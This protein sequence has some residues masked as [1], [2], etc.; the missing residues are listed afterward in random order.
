M[1]VLQLISSSGYYGTEAV[2]VSLSHALQQ[3]GVSSIV[4]VFR[5][6]SKPN[7]ELAEIAEAKALPVELIACNGRADRQ[8]W[9]AIREIIRREGIDVLHSHGYKAH[10]YGHFAARGT[11]CRTVATCHGHHTKNSN[12][13]VLSVSRVKVW[14]FKK[15]ERA[16]LPRFDR[17]IAV[18][19]QIASS[20]RTAGVQA[21]RLAVITNGIDV[22]EFESARPAS[23]LEY[24]KRG[25]LAIGLVGRLVYGKG[26]E[27]LLQIARNVLLQCPNTIFFIVGNGPRLEMLKNLARELDLGQSV[28]FVGKRNDMPQVYAALDALVLPSSAEGTPMAILEAMAAKKAVI[29][30]NVGGIPAIIS[31]HKTGRL[32]E[33]GDSGTFQE[34]VVSLLKSV[35][36]R[37]RLGS[38]GN[39]LVKERYSAS[40]M[41]TRYLTEYRKLTNSEYA[42][43][44][45]A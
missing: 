36:L 16:V 20:L 44:A 31:D 25:G 28:F 39:A 3:S 11:N 34:A 8:T 29:A 1:K 26:H 41:A 4:G 30:S 9:L 2:V 19:D 18:S 42:A 21:K 27:Q 32:V 13:G 15:I 23:D 10:L 33:P 12:K 35:D 14:G 43:G 38:A 24:L 6:A 5:N 40:H 45:T 17:V 22:A 37:C 7:L